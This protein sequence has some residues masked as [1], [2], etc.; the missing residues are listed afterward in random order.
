MVCQVALTEKAPLLG[1]ATCLWNHF[2]RYGDHFPGW[3]TVVFHICFFHCF[4]LLLTM[5]EKN[6]PLFSS[7]LSSTPVGRCRIRGMCALRFPRHRRQSSTDLNPWQRPELKQ[8]FVLNKSVGKGWWE[9]ASAAFTSRTLVSQRVWVCLAWL[10]LARSSRWLLR[11]STSWRPFVQFLRSW[12]AVAWQHF[13]E[14]VTTINKEWLA[15]ETVDS[16][17]TRGAVPIL[18]L[19]AEACGH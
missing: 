11:L 15:R 19:P 4:S 10:W 14:I 6:D 8:Y 12:K 7:S 5:K 16:S 3:A 13:L 9:P 1:P 2:P 18:C 17:K